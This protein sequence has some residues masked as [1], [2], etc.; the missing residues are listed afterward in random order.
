MAFKSRQHRFS[1]APQVNIQRS[2][3]DRS[4]THTT[5]FD[6]GYLI[7][8][9][10]DEVLPG[11][12]FK[13]DCSVFAR[14]LT[15]IVPFMDNVYLDTH[16]FFV[17]YR[18][19]WDHWANMHGE[20]KNPGD[21][22]DYVV[23]KIKF[24][25]KA[26][27]GESTDMTA[28]V[29]SIYDY[30]GIPTGKTGFSISALPL[31]AY[32]RIWN[33]WFRDENLQDSVFDPTDDGDVLPFHYTL[34]RR[35]KR[36]DYFTSAL[37][38]P[39]KGPGVEL[40]IGDYAPVKMEPASPESFTY[41]G[42]TFRSITSNG[43]FAGKQAR[44]R[45]GSETYELHLDVNGGT[46]GGAAYTMPGYYMAA[47]YADLSSAT[48]TTIN[49]LRQAFQIQR[50]LEASARGGTRYTEL[51]QSIFGVTNPDARLQRSE[52]LGGGSTHLS[53]YQVPQTASTDSTSP[54]GNLAA[55]A[56]A[57][58][59]RH[60]F[61]KS[62]TEFGVIIGLVSVRADLHYQ[63]GL[64]RMWTRS[65]RY[66]FYYPQLAHLGEQAILNQ[67]IYLQGGTTSTATDNADHQVF[68]YQ[69]R[70]AEY[71][72]QP[73]LI[74]GKLRSTVPQSLDV[75]HLAQKFDSLPTLSPAFI[76]ENP[77]IS[78]V[79]AVQNEP[80]FKLDSLVRLQCYRPMPMYSVPGL[81]DH[82]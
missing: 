38:W 26:E 75:W 72:Y 79:V 14:M 74:T 18:L 30:M 59:S 35:G 70:W 66:D 76:Q 58:D 57:S 15:P 68:G 45:T 21:S 80:Q 27:S 17:P 39:Q 50:L 3:F 13:C 6:A 9:Y 29:G 52:F 46:S 60:A 41:D 7:P 77:P 2:G 11:D 81:I 71:R 49:Q 78:R 40:P 65:S 31:R 37:P 63:Q 1:M 5:T 33:E 16:F 73:S 4:F 82:F 43:S 44:M 32:N 53:V 24:K 42:H 64:N 28:A 61:T 48:A 36:H 22:I 62:F 51:L 56:T 67:E 47:L 19:I 55:F 20:Q 54:Q 25:P 34:L 8:F 10:V 12:T 23:P 69:E